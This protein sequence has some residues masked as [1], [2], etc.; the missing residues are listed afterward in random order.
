MITKKLG[1]YTGTSTSGINEAIEDA[2][3]KAGDHSHF[4]VVETSSSQCNIK[5]KEYQVTLSTYTE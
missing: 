5:G 4:E 3:T 1:D 2:L